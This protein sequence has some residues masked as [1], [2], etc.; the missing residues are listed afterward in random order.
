LSAR[1]PA[2]AWI[3]R[4]TVQAIGAREVGLE[5][6]LDADVIVPAV[7]LLDPFFVA[8]SAYVRELVTAL[9]EREGIRG[10]EYQVITIHDLENYLPAAREVGLAIALQGK[11][12]DVKYRWHSTAYW[13]FGGYLESI[14]PGAKR[15]VPWLDEIWEDVFRDFRDRFPEL[16]GLPLPPA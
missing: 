1:S 9:L 5:V 10:F 14:A 13:E 8:N 12:A 3:R 7:V 2:C 15:R 16:R 6:F 11:M 4:C